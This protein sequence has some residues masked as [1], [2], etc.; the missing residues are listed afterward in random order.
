M[1]RIVDGMGYEGTPSADRWHVTTVDLGNGHREACVQ[2]AI[3]WKELGDWSTKPHFLPGANVLDARELALADAS[4]R[5]DDA[6]REEANAK[7]AAR[8]AK[9]NVRR[10]CK[11]LGL[12]TLLT[13]TYR[14][15][16]ADR[17]LCKA[18]VKEFLRRI[19]TCYRESGLGEF[20]YVGCLEPQKRGAWHVHF[21]VQK[22]PR[23]LA[24]SNGVKVVAH[25]VIRAIWLRVTGEWGGNIDDGRRKVFARKSAAKCAS[26][27]SKYMLKTH[28]QNGSQ[29]ASYLASRCDVPKATRAEFIADNMAE[30]IA[31][32]VSGWAG[33]DGRVI[34]SSWLS[35]F[36]DVFFV[37]GEAPS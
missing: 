21:A 17:D 3:D 5:A 25:R 11:A 37:A 35:R 15:L 6:D 1:L 9:T 23:F 16:Q 36:G 29:Q 26:Y 14:G 4:R 22:L 33:A 8:R 30:L 28:W 13:L 7:R 20:A 12:D 32:V 34:V 27:L 19:R 31:Q 10:R 24:A 18:H 2:R